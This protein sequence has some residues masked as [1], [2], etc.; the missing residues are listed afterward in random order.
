MVLERFKER[1]GP[2]RKILEERMRKGPLLKKLREQFFKAVTRV[3]D[4]DAFYGS[5]RDDLK[6]AKNL[7]VII[8]PF[9]NM[10]KVQKFVSTKEVKD[11]LERGVSVIVV[12]R[13]PET[14]QV[15]NVYWHRK[16]IELL[17][18]SH[19]KVVTVKEPRL[20]FKAVII[21]NEIIYLGS[22]NP[23]SVLTV[24]E[25][26]ADYMIR[27]ESEALVDEIVENAI[28]RKTYEHWLSN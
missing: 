25:I 5:L 28:G 20:H 9:L 15:G 13:P 26:P 6:D 11:A 10:D 1:K 14:D 4:A 24:R 16:C 22:I 12:T 17:K 18:D 3:Y 19:I 21:D 2:L 27:F 8:S 23:L 7:V